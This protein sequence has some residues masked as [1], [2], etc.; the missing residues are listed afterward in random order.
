VTDIVRSGKPSGRGRDTV[1]RGEFQRCNRRRESK[2][3]FVEHVV[4][5]PARRTRSSERRTNVPF[6][7]IKT[8]N[9]P[10]GRAA[11][12]TRPRLVTT[13]C[14]VVFGLI[15]CSAAPDLD[16]ARPRC[17]PE[18]L[19]ALC[20]RAVEE[21]DLGDILEIDFEARLRRPACSSARRGITSAAR[22]SDP[23]NSLAAL[24]RNWPT[25]EASK[26]CRWLRTTDASPRISESPS[27]A[28]EAT[29]SLAGLLGA[30][31]RELP[32][33][34]VRSECSFRP[35]FYPLAARFVAREMP[36]AATRDSILAYNQSIELYL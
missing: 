26:D 27:R 1:W 18:F 16:R 14:L 4:G 12:D 33:A 10:G 23:D 15:C 6:R 21:I 31:S 29:S 8:A 9:Q 24:R 2:P 34:R 17:F 30:S 32:S 20:N 36:A 22:G 7:S 28:I 25:D 11:I 35:D 19:N 13:L 3:I 5:Q